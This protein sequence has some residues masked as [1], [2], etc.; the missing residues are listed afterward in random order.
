MAISYSKISDI[1][2]NWAANDPPIEDFTVENVLYAAGLDSSHYETV[3][4]Y[5]MAKTGFELIPKKMLVCPSNH[6]IQ[7]FDL[8]EELEGELFDCFCGE[9]DFEA[10]NF[11]LVFSFTDEFKQDALKKKTMKAQEQ[12]HLQLV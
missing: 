11:I 5:L 4:R 3:L 12:K 10:D 2:L 8:D 7:A 6:K 9:S 1:L